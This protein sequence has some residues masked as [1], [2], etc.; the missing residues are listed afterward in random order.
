MSDK[1]KEIEEMED[2]FQLMYLAST[3]IDGT[4]NFFKI[5]RKISNVGKPPYAKYNHVYNLI[6]HVLKPSDRTIRNYSKYFQS[7]Y[8]LIM[9]F[10]LIVANK[11]D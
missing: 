2:E 4:F 10:I 7:I 11:L 6:S 9:S 5:E 3:I 8:Q 1:S